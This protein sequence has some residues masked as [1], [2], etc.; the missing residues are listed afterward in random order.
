MRTKWFVECWCF[1]K[2]FLCVKAMRIV[3]GMLQTL[4]FCISSP[5]QRQFNSHA[6]KV[7]QWDLFIYYTAHEFRFR[8][9]TSHRNSI[10]KRCSLLMM[11]YPWRILRETHSMLSRAFFII[12]F[13]YFLF[14]PRQLL[15]G[16]ARCT[17]LI[18]RLH[19]THRVNN[20]CKILKRQRMLLLI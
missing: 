12:F 3:L 17:L 15:C 4:Q 1:L 16:E 14:I 19:S 11:I 6:W 5:T 2:S 7:R 10:I 13:L 20:K 8:Q 18:R 9:R